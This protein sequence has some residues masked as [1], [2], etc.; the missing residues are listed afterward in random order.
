[1][2]NLGSLFKKRKAAKVHSSDSNS[3][4][5]GPLGKL[6]F[7]IQ[8]NKIKNQIN[9]PMI[10]KF[11]SRKLWAA[12]VG[13]AIATLGHEIGLSPDMT[14]WAVTVIT[15]YIVGQGIADA[16]ANAGSQGIK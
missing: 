11:K 5:S 14:Q 12:V 6:K 10:K 13:T 8:I 16:G 7:L 9:K 3:L 4:F 2:Q 1:M 15:G